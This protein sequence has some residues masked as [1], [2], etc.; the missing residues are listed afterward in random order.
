MK[1]KVKYSLNEA[2]RYFYYMY[3]FKVNEE[4][5]IKTFPI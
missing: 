1:K 4:Q 3:D 2:S 5:A